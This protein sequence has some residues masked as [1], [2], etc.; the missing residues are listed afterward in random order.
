MVMH[1]LFKGSYYNGVFV[2]VARDWAQLLQ[3][4]V[5]IYSQERRWKSVDE[6]Y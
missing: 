3:E 2:A 5:G 4:Q 6:K 1:I